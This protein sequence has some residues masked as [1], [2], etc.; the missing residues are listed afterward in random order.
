MNGQNDV[1]RFQLVLQIAGLAITLATA[2]GVTFVNKELAETRILI[3]EK[4]SAATADLVQRRE[5]D[6]LER[7][8]SNIES[9]ERGR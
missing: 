1:G 5:F 7:R 4:I 8:V 6:G 3:M 2:A 9:R